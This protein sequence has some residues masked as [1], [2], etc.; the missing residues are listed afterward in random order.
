MTSPQTPSGMIAGSVLP[1]R[2]AEELIAT[3]PG[4]LSVRIV[5][6]E[7]GAV[8]EIHVLT[9][10]LV[11]PKNTV[12]NIESALM[13]QLGLRVNHRKISIATTLDAPRAADLPPAAQSPAG[14]SAMAGGAAAPVAPAPAVPATASVASASP[15]GHIGG[16]P[17]AA[18]AISPLGDATPSGRRVL[19]FEDV[20]VRRSR[21]RGVLCRVTLSRDGQEFVGESEGQ[22]SERSRIDLAARSTLL[23]IV[24][25]TKATPG[26]ERSLALEGS[27]LI[28]AFDRE[29]IF[30]SV[31]AR[32]GREPVVLTG[33]C[34]V[35]ESAETSA[36]LA[37]LDATNRWMHID[38]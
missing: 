23:A 35:R 11:L 16:P 33:S 26:G 2:R 17:R 1:I 3:L 27:K 37:V 14:L 21:S 5:P 19:V 28:D 8:D 10:D 6:N 9:T 29:F 15:G 34:E 4:V 31:A 13:A 20:E 30:V 38:R 12:R 7:T 22:E 25:A 36:V 24:S 32:V 18:A